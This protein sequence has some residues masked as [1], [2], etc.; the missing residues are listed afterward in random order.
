MFSPA[1]NGMPTLPGPT[2]QT[3]PLQAR[4][5]VSIT[6]GAGAAA[7][8]AAAPTAAVISA[9]VMIMILICRRM[10]TS[11]ACRTGLA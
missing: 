7:A 11:L 5:D 8:G 4:F 2:S 9:P 1:P 3:L 10:P 6:G